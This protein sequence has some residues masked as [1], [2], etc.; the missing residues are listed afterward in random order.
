[1]CALFIIWFIVLVALFIV[2][3]GGI[4]WDT[5]NY[6]IGI[7]V[8]AA[9]WGILIGAYKLYQK[10][11]RK[12]ERLYKEKYITEV[13]IE[14][15]FFGKMTFED[16][17]FKGHMRSAELH[18]PKFGADVLDTLYIEGYN[19]S[20]R[21]KIFRAFQGIYEHQNEILDALCPE[22]LDIAEEYGEVDENGAPYTLEKIRERAYI[23]WT[24]VFN[25]DE[26]V[27]VI[28]EAG[29]T[30]GEIELGGHGFDVVINCADKI[31]DFTME[32]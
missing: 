21:E 3:F 31:M 22:L 32:G 17:S 26:G 5:N 15:A 27:T 19:E 23:S 12:K 29:L 4:I 24:R 14:D 6:V 16:D 7:P 18:F 20:D 10:R 9:W 11:E 13:S 25:D 30:E 28:M 1:M 2:F 8:I